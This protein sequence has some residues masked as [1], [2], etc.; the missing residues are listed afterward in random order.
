MYQWD[1]SVVTNN[2]DLLAYGAVTTVELVVITMATALVTGLAVAVARMSPSRLLRHVAG[3]YTEIFRD[4]PLLVQLYIVYRA[5]T[6]SSFMAGYVGLTLNLTAF[7]AEVYRS[8]LNSIGRGQWEAALTLGMRP[9]QV[10]LRIIIPQAVMRVVPP[11]GTFWVSLFRD[12]ALVSIIGVA[13]LTHAAQKIS[14][15][16]YRP[17]EAF[18]ALAI[19]YIVLTLPQARLVSWLHEKF[20]V[21]E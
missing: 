6:W 9:R 19:L 11:L 3:W 20:R 13:E 5:T 4:T 7:L 21:R 16:T 12:S 10:L 8:G 1:W 15:E 17:F 2:W 18:T 14:T